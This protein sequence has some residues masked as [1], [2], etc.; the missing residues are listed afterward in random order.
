MK[1]NE[2]LELQGWLNTL[3]MPEKWIGIVLSGLEKL[4]EDN[5]KSKQIQKVIIDR[6]AQSFSY[7]IDGEE[8]VTLPMFKYCEIAQY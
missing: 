4:E 7:Q 6:D 3:N 2:K 5:G 1:E 8:W